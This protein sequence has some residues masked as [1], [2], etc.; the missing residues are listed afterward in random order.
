MHKCFLGKETPME[1]RVSDDQKFFIVDGRPQFILADTCWSAFTH[2]S[3]DEWREYLDYRHGQNF[4]AIQ[5]NLLQQ[6][7][8]CL[9]HE[10]RHPFAVTEKMEYDYTHIH[11]DY[12][13]RVEVFLDE[14]ASRK[15]IPIIVLLWGNYAPDSM[16]MIL[17]KKEDAPNVEKKPYIHAMTFA[18]M[19]SYV[20]YAVNRLK[21]YKPIFVISGDINLNEGRTV[22][23]GSPERE[24]RFGD[25]TP[26]LNAFYREAM[27]ITKACAPECLATFHI[28]PKM[29]LPKC[30]LEDGLMDFYMY[31]PGHSVS[32]RNLDRDLAHEIRNYDPKRPIYN[33]ETCYEGNV[34]FDKPV[35]RFDERDVRKAFWQSILSGACCGF[36][37]GA[38]GVWLWRERHRPC[39]NRRVI[40][41]VN[42]WRE[43]LSLRG[44]WEVS[45]GRYLVE[46]YGLYDADPW[47]IIGENPNGEFLAAANGDKRL[48]AVYMPYSYP[49]EIKWD[50]KDYDVLVIDLENR[51]VWKPRLSLEDAQTRIDQLALAYD[52]LIIAR[53]KSS[54]ISK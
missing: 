13:H 17:M 51:N 32:E 4:N 37:Y 2:P 30:L 46:N 14:M 11:E 20:R 15:M 48:I 3:L 34:A 18:E 40:G 33:S 39:S 9:P 44:A 12:F 26:Q 16:Q 42:N 19:Q 49:L 53:K 27:R 54:V 22:I 35:K 45:F 38:G 24:Y 25:S 28:C 50:L 1:L 5:M 36:T 29:T 43:D 8:S 7:H 31:Q 47:D 23:A 41:Q 10:W 6:C 52:C 21:K